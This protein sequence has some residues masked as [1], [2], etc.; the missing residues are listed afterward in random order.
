MN[1][2][3]SFRLRSSVIC[4]ASFFK[5]ERFVKH[6]AIINGS[7][8]IDEKKHVYK[9]DMYNYARDRDFLNCFYTTCKK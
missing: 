7:A 6:N 5:P 2:Q 1:T 4:S 3:P 9:G 8:A